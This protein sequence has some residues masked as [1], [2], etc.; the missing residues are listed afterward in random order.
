M[1]AAARPLKAAYSAPATGSRRT[2]TR[3]SSNTT[4]HPVYKG[5]STAGKFGQQQIRVPLGSSVSHKAQ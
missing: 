3:A 5:S 1:S 2:R 4:T